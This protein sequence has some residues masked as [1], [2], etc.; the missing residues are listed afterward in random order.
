MEEGDY[1]D[2]HFGRE[3]SRKDSY[4]DK[5]LMLESRR[6]KT[7]RASSVASKTLTDIVMRQMYKHD[8]ADSSKKESEV[9]RETKLKEN[10]PLM[11]DQEAQVT[12]VQK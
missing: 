12:L 7:D 11:R 9:P 8:L 5:S 2:P 1:E 3:P 6:E 10:H 4:A